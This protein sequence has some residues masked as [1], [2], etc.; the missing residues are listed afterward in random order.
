[1]KPQGAI[2]VIVDFSSCLKRENDI[3]LE[4]D[5]PFCERLL[6]RKNVA[7]VPGTAF[8]SPGFVRISYSCSKEDICEGV[9]RFIEYLE[10]IHAVN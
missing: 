7:M 2:Y 6:E 10:E 1:M 9:K 3:Y 5:G 4:N 8:L